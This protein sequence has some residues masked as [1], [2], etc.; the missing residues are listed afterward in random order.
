MFADMCLARHHHALLVMN[1][2]NH[3][4]KCTACFVQHG[5][6]VPMFNQKYAQEICH[7]QFPNVCSVHEVLTCSLAQWLKVD[8]RKTSCTL[9]GHG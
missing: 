3:L 8:R 7:T 1:I 2:I 9:Q 6:L 4:T 5:T